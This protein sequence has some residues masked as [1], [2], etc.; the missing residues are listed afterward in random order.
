MREY[1]F[2]N[3]FEFFFEFLVVVAFQ[4]WK[5]IKDLVSVMFLDRKKRGTHLMKLEENLF[6]VWA[7]FTEGQVVLSLNKS[8]YGGE[9]L[10]ELD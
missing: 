9:V 2:E 10:E 4:A 8:V 7:C 1:L 6:I 5:I 3:W